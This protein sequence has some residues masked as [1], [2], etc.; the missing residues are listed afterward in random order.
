MINTTLLFLIK[1]D[2]QKITEVCLAMKKRGFGEGRWNGVGGK[3]E[4]NE[5]VKQGA[6]RET[7][8]EIKV[9]PKKL[10]RIA[11]LEF[12]FVHNPEWNQMVTVYF[13][14]EWDGTPEETE[15]MKPAWFSVEDVPFDQMWPDDIFWVPEVIKDK[16][17]KAFFL[18][19]KNDVIKDKK[20][21]IVEQF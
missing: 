15:E 5:T 8:E 16:K 19:G 6:E 11:L 18:F 9:T 10:K 3:V 14:E 12:N 4:K 2:K 13:S 17:V 21:K 20:V 1:R 7:R